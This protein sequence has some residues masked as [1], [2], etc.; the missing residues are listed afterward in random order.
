MQMPEV[1]DDSRPQVLPPDLLHP[2]EDLEAKYGSV[3]T[4]D[5][6]RPRIVPPSAATPQAQPAPQAPAAVEE[7]DP[8]QKELQVLQDLQDTDGERNPRNRVVDRNGGWR[9]GLAG[10]FDQ[11]HENYLAQV[12]SGQ[13]PSMS[14]FFQM[15]GAG[16]GGFVGGA[17]NKRADELRH[18]YE[19]EIP[20]QR[21]RVADMIQTRDAQQKYETAAVQNLQRV[22]QIRRENS[23]EN[24]DA[25]N[26][27]QNQVMK[28]L[29]KYERLDPENPYHQELL[30]KA[31]KAGLTVDPETWNAGN[32]QTITNNIT[33]VSYRRKRGSDAWEVVSDT[34]G[35]PVD[36]GARDTGEVPKEYLALDGE[37]DD[38]TIET[39]AEREAGKRMPQDAQLDDSKLAILGNGD[40]AEGKRL[41]LENISAGMPG[42]SLRDY[43]KDE[44]KHRFDAAK[45]EIKLPM[46]R[47]LKTWQGFVKAVSRDP[48][49]QL[50]T[51]ED[52]RQTFNLFEQA[53]ERIQND[54]ALDDGAKKEKINQLKTETF[55]TLRKVRLTG[56]E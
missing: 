46:Q 2:G 24:R 33:G 26:D 12:A 55:Q 6:A 56:P 36:A 21:Q 30:V 44:D 38:D 43:M 47:R 1:E 40:A 4:P 9:S 34:E 35:N 3:P 28:E 15:I 41:L 32:T 10:F 53:V 13:R 7:E 50:K 45:A 31:Q 17:F 37:W 51:I 8:V 49:A 39:Y 16:A 29:E 11:V 22:A 18:R 48:R 42:F 54:K 20:R 27:Q 19:V 14:S 5:A 25:L 23:K 52:V